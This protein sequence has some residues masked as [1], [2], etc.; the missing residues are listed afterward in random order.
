MPLPS[1]SP[2]PGADEAIWGWVRAE[3]TANTCFGTAAKVRAK[4]DA[5]FHDI[6][7]RASEVTQR[8][9]TALQASAERLIESQ[10]ACHVDPVAA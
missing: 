7:D 10:D 8:C 9:R 1:Y 3:V 6:A 5:F 2:D 4:V